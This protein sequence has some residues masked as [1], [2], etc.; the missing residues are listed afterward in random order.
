MSTSQTVLRLSS[1]I[2]SS[3]R[4]RTEHPDRSQRTTRATKRSDE[5]NTRSDPEAPSYLDQPRG[6]LALS[7]LAP[8]SLKLSSPIQ[9]KREE[10]SLQ[11]LRQSQ[12][13]RR[14]RVKKES[15]SPSPRILLG[16]PRRQRSPP[17]QQSLTPLEHSLLSKFGQR[18]ATTAASAPAA[19]SVPPDADNVFSRRCT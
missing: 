14:V 17:R 12:S 4:A 11:T 5:R 15:R 13:L 10:I 3:N 19:S 16:P 9:I 18:K 8:V 1:T 2:A 7:P 6:T